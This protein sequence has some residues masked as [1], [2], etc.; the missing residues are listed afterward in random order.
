MTD[1]RIP[2]PTSVHVSLCMQFT[3]DYKTM[4]TRIFPT[5]VSGA[6]QERGVH[7][8]V[9]ITGSITE[10]YITIHYIHIQ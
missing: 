9:R 4:L 5:D 6:M 10:T 8:V 2:K 3:T 1:K 7:M